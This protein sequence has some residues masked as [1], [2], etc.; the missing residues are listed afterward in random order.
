M[1]GID[2]LTERQQLRARLLAAGS[3]FQLGVAAESVFKSEDGKTLMAQAERLSSHV[4]SAGDLL[5]DDGL[6]PIATDFFRKMQLRGVVTL[7]F[8]LIRDYCR[9]TEQQ[10]ALI[11]APWYWHARIVRNCLSHDFR[12]SYRADDI[13]EALPVEW[14]ERV[15][16]ESM[17]GQPLSMGHF[18]LNAVV[19]LLE[20]CIDFADGLADA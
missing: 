6:G 9:A 2:T 14:N 12:I 4:P 20:E 5:R 19:E 11:A 8:E 15:F 10:D 1:P 16:D 13:R 3:A 7:V 18:D 17:E